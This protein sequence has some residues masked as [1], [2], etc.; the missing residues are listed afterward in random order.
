MAEFMVPPDLLNALIE[1]GFNDEQEAILTQQLVE[2]LRDKRTKQPDLIQSRDMNVAPS[3]LANVAATLQ[4]VLGGQQEQDLYRRMTEGQRQQ[5]QTAGERYKLMQDFMMSQGG[6]PAV[7]QAPSAAPAAGAQATAG[8]QGQGGES[9]A[10]VGRRVYRDENGNEVPESEKVGFFGDSYHGPTIDLRPGQGTFLADTY[11]GPEIDLR[12]GKGNWMGNAYY[13]PP[14]DMRPGKGTWL[15]QS[16]YGPEIDL[17]KPTDAL[18]ALLRAG[19]G[20]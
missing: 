16:Y 17:Q 5:A 20:A 3:P 9:P 2:A 8:A 15:G 4:Q 10:L 13:G 12:E 1:S 19:N 18:V 14:V 6:Q 7:A 11:Y